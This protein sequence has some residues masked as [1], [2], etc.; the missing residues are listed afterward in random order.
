MKTAKVMLGMLAGAAAGADALDSVVV[1][2]G[3]FG[4]AAPRPTIALA[5]PTM[6]KR[7]ITS[8]S[9]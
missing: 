2:A 6:R 5:N 9:K 1:T 7:S 4:A 8:P 3:R